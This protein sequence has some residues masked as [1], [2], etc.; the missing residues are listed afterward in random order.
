MTAT[1]SVRP[2]N[3]VVATRSACQ[4]LVVFDSRVADLSTL[5]AALLPGSKGVVIPEQA[6]ALDFITTILEASGATELAIVA[7]GEPGVIHLG[8]EPITLAA[9]Q[10]HADSL[11]G[12]GVNS[13]ALYACEVGADADFVAQFG[14]LTGAHIAAAVGKV[15][16]AALGGRWELVGAATQPFV[17]QQLADYAGVL[18]N[19]TLTGRN[20]NLNGNGTGTTSGD[21]TIFITGPGR[22]D[23]GDTL[24][25]GSG[26][27]TIDIIYGNNGATPDPAAVDFSVV[28]NFGG[29]ERIT[30]GGTNAYDQ[31]VTLSRTQFDGLISIDLGNGTDKLIINNIREQDGAFTLS[32]AKIFGI[33]STELSGANGQDT[34]TGSSLADSINGGNG[35]DSLTGG[36][37]NDTIS[38]GGGQGDY[39]VYDGN[40]S[41]YTITFN[42]STSK[43]TIVDNRSGSPNGTDTVDTVENFQFADGVVTDANILA[44]FVTSVAYGTNDGTLKA[45][46]SVTLV[47]TFSE[48]V[49]VAGGSPT[50]TLNSGGTASLTSGSGTNTLTFTYTVAAGNSTADLAITAFNLNGATIRN[51]TRNA[52]LSGAVTNPTGTLVVDTTATAGTLSL[53][54]FTDSGSNPSDFISNDNTFDLSL[55]GTESGAEVT[56]EVSTNGGTTWSSTNTAQSDLGDGSYQFRAVVTDAAG[57]TS[58]SNVV[59]MT[60]DTRPV[61]SISIGDVTVIE[62]IDATA[63]VTVTLSGTWDQ[64][65]TVQY[66]TEG[67]SGTA[68]SDFTAANGTITFNPG[69]TSQTFNIPIAILNDGASEPDETFK[70]V[71]SNA[72]NATIADN[73]GVVTITDTRSSATSTV[74][75]ATVEN[76]VLTGTGNI[77]GTGNTLDNTITGNAGNNQLMGGAGLDVLYG[78]LGND[79]LAGDDGSDQLYGGDGID[80]LT[81]GNGDD[82][83]A[84]GL[85]QDALYGNA[86]ADIFQFNFGDS[87]VSAPDRVFDFNQT[88]GDRF[89]TDYPAGFFNA[90]TV[91]GANLTAAVLAA[92]GDKNQ[93]DA[94]AQAL[95]ANEAVMFRLG[96]RTYLAMNNGI[97]GF[98]AANDLVVEM[99]G[100]VLAAGDSTAGS[101]SVDNYFLGGGG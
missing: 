4:T 61:P 65:V 68:G 62:G 87:L 13:I 93:V 84:G 48:A 63:S 24:L 81:G 49:T 17:T 55:T 29:I 33:E 95:G 78:G 42:S 15:G 98:D 32:D 97:A 35:N 91:V 12:W 8:A 21:D 82:F 72:T 96:T 86:G 45:A 89:L 66:A 50:L 57:N 92:F 60:V 94:G 99:T 36:A 27:D 37:G 16:A 25:G 2:A 73:T 22:I 85:G 38:G 34:I 67:M 75:D 71:L 23:A 40:R 52:L 101:L 80:R 58:N 10:W 6:E 26:T 56:Y 74:L 46:E 90:G 39:A 88:A 19:V 76:L 5:Q 9:L 59:S 83:L 31:A 79:S 53:N 1:L 30:G 51:G 70:V 28:A 77:N 18:A 64:A 44:P 7:H 41:D 14:E 54:N 47:V 11:A 100:A 43:Y 69:Q 20:D 3:T